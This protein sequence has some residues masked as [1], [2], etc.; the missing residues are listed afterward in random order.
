MPN[1]EHAAHIYLFVRKE[2]E[3]SGAKKFEILRY[4]VHSF[5]IDGAAAGKTALRRAD[6]ATVKSRFEQIRRR[7]NVVLYIKSTREAPT[8]LLIEA[9]KAGAGDF[10][11]SFGVRAVRDGA[12]TMS[13]TSVQAKGSFAEPPIPVD[14]K[15]PLLKVKLTLAAPTFYYG[16]REKNK[17]NLQKVET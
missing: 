3:A 7:G 9:A 15:P 14:G 13:S 6:A 4:Y 8:S 16:V 11:V 1:I 2:G 12:I 5:E 17:M 10:T